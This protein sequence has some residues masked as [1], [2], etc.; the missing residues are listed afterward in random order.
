M[1][2]P[3]LS[4]FSSRVML[5]IAALLISLS[6]LNAG[7]A[8]EVHQ[9]AN[10]TERER[11]QSLIDE[12]RCPKCQNQ[13]LSGSDS[14]IAEDLRK[15]IYHQIK[16][17]KA[18]KEIVDYMVARYGEFILYKPTLSAKNLLLWATPIGLLLVG[19][20][21][22]ALIV[23]QRRNA[24]TGAGELSQAERAKLDA[25]LKQDRDSQSADSK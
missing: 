15:E 5:C 4:F 24:A 19:A 21:V 23:R 7:A 25:L 16:E 11:Y 8:I 9:F 22:L 14:P 1:K 17:G 20:L 6:S 12:M 10:E 18:D 2:L 13:N 3:K